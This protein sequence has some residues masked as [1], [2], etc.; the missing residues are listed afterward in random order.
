MRSIFTVVLTCVATL[1][2]AIAGCM[3][4]AS[5]PS[6]TNPGQPTVL[7]AKRLTVAI[8]GEPHTLSQAINSAGTGSI[9]GVGEVEKMIHAGLTSFDSHGAVIP[10]LA[11]QAPATDNGL[12]RVLSDGRM[13]TEWRLKP[14]VAWHDGVA[15]TA[16]D[17][18]FSAKVARDETLA[19]PSDPGYKFIT[20]IE[21]KDSRTIVVHWEKPYIDAN[22]LFGYGFILPLP[23][24][25]LAEAYAENKEGLLELPYWTTDF[26]GA[27]PFQVREFI[28]SS[29]VDLRASSAY[30]L[31]TPKIDQVLVKF[32][33]DP[34]VLIANILSGE[35]EMSLGRGLSLE[36]AIEVDERWD[37][38]MEGHPSNWV[39][40]YPQFLTPNPEVIKDVNFRRALIHAMDRKQISDRLQ[41][42]R[43]PVAHAILPPSAPDYAPIESRIVK[44][45]YDPRRAAQLIEGL[46]YQKRADGLFYDPAGQKLQVEARTNAGDDF[47]EK[48]LLASADFWK[49]AGVDVDVV[50]SPRQRASDREYRASY[51]GFDLV[52]QPFD[53]TRFR[54][55]ESPLPENKWRGNNRMRYSNPEL[56]QLIDQFFTTIPL[57]ARQ[58]IVGGMMHILT[59]Q[60][61]ALGVIY[62]VEP[63]LIGK[64][65]VNVGGDLAQGVDD[66]WNVEQWDLR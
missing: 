56:D 60:A 47:K 22:R 51:P 52:R 59:D 19:L 5:S 50:I 46:G 25:L 41:A 45:D 61:V 57:A 55:S 63:T 16:D 28:R 24:H 1:S 32:L 40:H 23:Q 6:S 8:L 49:A 66:T 14:G 34:N 65:L 64:R 7:E 20:S 35:V 2:V 4:S 44:Y 37:G 11:E 26:V 43:A 33:Q 42:G 62:G 27:G 39:A 18:L 13:E 17:L 12:W 58:L 38:R 36:Q 21:A 54:S 29:H 53:P 30:A 3:P 9:R 10:Q 15:M 31:G 48:M